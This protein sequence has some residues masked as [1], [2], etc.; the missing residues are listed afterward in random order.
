MSDPPTREARRARLAWLS[1][2]VVGASLAVASLVVSDSLI[3]SADEAARATLVP[4]IGALALFVGVGSGTSVWLV[5]RGAHGTAYRF[6]AATLVASSVVLVLVA[7][8][9]K[10]RPERVLTAS[11]REPLRE[12]RLASGEM[13]VEHPRLGFR[14]PHPDRP[15]L[16][17]PW[18]EQSAYERGGEAYER[19]HA[20]FAFQSTVRE[21]GEASG[22]SEP[23][24][25][26]ED[27]VTLMIDL[28]EA[29]GLDDEALEGLTESAVGSFERAGQRVTRGPIVREGRCLHRA[30]SGA[31]EEGDE[32]GRAE[33]A[34]AIFR[35]PE[36]PRVLRLAV[37][38]VSREGGFA[39]YLERLELPCG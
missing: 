13:G 9:A 11:D 2:I 10:P 3:A 28:S 32:A 12:A 14:L 21:G 33:L 37:T 27:F 6:A 19:E 29:S 34:L 39:S 26:S 30:A 25:A 36:G 23:S 24:E 16:P 18:L 4:T 5:L 35:D 22:A 38:I 31:F 20:L 15:F 1:S 8:T 7:R 17:A